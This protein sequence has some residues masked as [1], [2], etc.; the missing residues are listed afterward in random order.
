MRGKVFSLVL[1][2]Y[3]KR[4]TP[5]YA[6]KRLMFRQIGAGSK[7]HPRVCG[8]KLSG[9]V[10]LRVYG[11]SPPRMRGKVNRYPVQIPV[12]GITPAYAGKR[13]RSPPALRGGKD[14]PRV[15]GEKHGVHVS[16]MWSAGSP[17]RMRGK[18]RKPCSFTSCIGITPAYAGKST[19]HVFPDGLP[20]DHPRVCG[21]KKAYKDGKEEGEGSPPRMRGKEKTQHVVVKRPGITPAY[22]GKS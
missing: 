12:N 17:P 6:G 3:T 14:H 1:L 15:C 20:W 9:C 16:L 11:G 2:C 5:A 18:A 22:A 4:I 19:F 7:D 21:E 13:S 10:W 8:E